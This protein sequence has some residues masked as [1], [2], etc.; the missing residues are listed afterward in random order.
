VVIYDRDIEP[1]GSKK[2][3]GV[4]PSAFQVVPYTIELM[5]MVMMAVTVV[6]IQIYRNS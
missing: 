6:E 2:Y 3:R 1:L 5:V 4:W